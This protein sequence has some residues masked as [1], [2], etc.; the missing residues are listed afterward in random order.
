MTQES[1]RG[2][3]VRRTDP[4]QI[5]LIDLVVQLWRGKVTIIVSIIVMIVLTAAYLLIAKEK[6]TSTTVV[7]QPDVAQIAT[8]NSAL[9]VLYPDASINVTDIQNRVMGRYAVALSALSSELDNQDIPEQLTIEPVIKGRDYPIRVSYVGAS[10]E[11]AQKTLAQYLQKVDEQIADELHLDLNDNIKQQVLALSSSLE[12]Q[13]TVAEEQ[14][15]IRIRQ[16]KEALK[17]AEEAKITKP[18]VQQTQEVTQDTMFLLGSEGLSAMVQNESTRPLVLPANYFQTKINLLDIQ[19]I[20]VD[21]KTIHA[22][23]YVM[24]PDL[25]ISRDSPK[26]AIMLILSVMLG[27]MI[28]SGIVLGRNALREYRN[29]H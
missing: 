20:K 9:K 16:L 13:Q 19:R 29:R 27:G 14:R 5:D 26:R 15:A 4:E 8:Y 11:G 10:A 23:R 1:N 6:W 2:A 17:Y 22:Y 18:Q 24:K 3:T 21:P 28:G 7:A 12:T 25:P